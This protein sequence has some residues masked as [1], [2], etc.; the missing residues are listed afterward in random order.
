M[1]GE[2]DQEVGVWLLAIE[3]AVLSSTAAHPASSMPLPTPQQRRQICHSWNE[4]CSTYLRCR[5]LHACGVCLGPYPVILCREKA[6]APLRPWQVFL[7]RTPST[8]V[9]LMSYNKLMGK[10]GAFS[11]LAA[12]QQGSIQFT[13]CRPIIQEMLTN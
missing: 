11:P 10:V 5:F 4:N 6:L 2:S 9:R 7:P 3:S 12:T 1:S 8:A 13:K